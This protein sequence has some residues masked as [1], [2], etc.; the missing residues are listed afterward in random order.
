MN[1]SSD[2][3]GWAILVATF[4]GP[5]GAV[6]VTRLIDA[7]R[8]EYQRRLTIFRTLMATRAAGLNPERIAALNMIQIDFAKHSEVLTAWHNLLNHY[9]TPVP[10]PGSDELYY[11][12]RNRLSTVL[13]HEMSKKLRI[14]IEQLDILDRVYYP[15]GL[16]SME[17][18]Q[19]AIRRL[20]ADIASGRRA[21]PIIAYPP[22]PI[23]P[24]AE[25]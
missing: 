15:I 1:P 25:Q 20:F 6:F 18:D 9:G 8:E 12:E 11:R 7:R 13:L 14:K 5:V 22:P 4:V 10:A 2:V 19:D 23:E 24:T 3:F 17:N 16:A 21:L